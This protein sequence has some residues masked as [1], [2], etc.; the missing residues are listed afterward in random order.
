MTVDT[1]NNLS[2]EFAVNGFV[3]VPGVVEA[4]LLNAISLELERVADH[5][6]LHARGGSIYAAR[7]VFAVN[8][9]LLAMASEG[10]LLQLAR[11]LAGPE[12]RATKATYFDKRPEANWTLPL[13]QDLTITVRNRAEVPGYTHWS[14]KAG[15]PHVQP[16]VALLQQIVALRLH[17]DDCPVENGALEVVPGSHRQGRIGASELRAMHLEGRAVACPAIAGDVLAMRPLLVH[18]SRKAVAPGRRRVLHIE[19]CAAALDAPLAWPD[20]CA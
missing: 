3:R 1:T 7:D 12:A 17:L 2:E 14:V 19:Y 13:H 9:R 8:S 5:D 18:G 4:G 16:P 10:P 15:V 20:W 6:K 11:E